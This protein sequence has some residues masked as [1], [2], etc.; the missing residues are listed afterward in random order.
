[1]AVSA[2]F[3]EVH[4]VTVLPGLPIGESADALGE[5]SVA[6][7]SAEGESTMIKSG[8]VLILEMLDRVTNEIVSESVATAEEFRSAQV[9]LWATYR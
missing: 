4:D 9:P 3:F 5:A 8:Y 2:E 7:A 1:M 6:L